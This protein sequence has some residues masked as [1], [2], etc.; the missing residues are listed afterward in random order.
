MLGDLLFIGLHLVHLQSS[1]LPSSRWSI[2]RDHGFAEMFQYLKFA[3]ICLALGYLFVRTR[4]RALLGWVAVFAFLLLDDAGRIHERCGLMFAAWA[5]L[6][7]H[8]ALRGRDIGELIYA[9]FAGLL[10]VPTAAFGCLR[11]VQSA[12]AISADLT[13][14]LLAFAA[15][16]VGADLVHQMLSAT[17]MDMAAGLFEDG[18]EMLVLSLTCAYVIQWVTVADS[19]HGSQVRFRPAKLLR[20]R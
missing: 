3:A 10:V 18:G 12:R 2:A 17:F 16:A 14:L 15:C 1:L 13:V 4:I 7:D 20:H 6:P 8:G 11:D 19:K 5:H 9:L